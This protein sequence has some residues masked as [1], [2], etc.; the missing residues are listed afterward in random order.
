V[1]SGIEGTGFNLKQ[2]LRGSL[3]VFSDGVPMASTGKEGAKD[4]E[5]QG[6]LE[7]IE[8]VECG[9]NVDTLHNIV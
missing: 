2:V 4:Q 7:E 9:H 3:D 1:Q 8:A 5:I 6:S